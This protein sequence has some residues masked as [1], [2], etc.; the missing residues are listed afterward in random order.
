[1]EISNHKAADNADEHD[2]LIFPAEALSSQDR[3]QQR[4]E[5]YHRLRKGTENHK[6]LSGLIKLPKATRR[7]TVS[8]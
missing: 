7:R 4:E 2:N 3:R 6:K 1:M 8:R 5:G